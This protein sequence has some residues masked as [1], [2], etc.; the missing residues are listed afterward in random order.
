MKR[1]SRRDQYSS[2]LSL[3]YGRQAAATLCLDGEM[4]DVRRHRGAETPS[5]AAPE[6]PASAA[7]VGT[8]SQA[9]G[10]LQGWKLASSGWRRE[11]VSATARNRPSAPDPRLKAAGSQPFVRSLGRCGRDLLAM[12]FSGFNPFRSGFGADSVQRL[13]KISDRMIGIVPGLVG[14]AAVVAEPGIFRIEPGRL[15]VVGDRPVVIAPAE[16]GRAASSLPPKKA[17]TSMDAQVLELAC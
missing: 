12:S 11:M 15:I 1:V 2:M 17:V 8:V 7:I 13:V 10:L 5:R 9:E 4:S 14:F 3:L 6:G 16:V